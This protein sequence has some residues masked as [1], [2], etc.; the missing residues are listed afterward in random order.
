MK[1]KFLLFTAIITSLLFISCRSIRVI[2]VE[3][4][5]P[6]AIT[7]PPE[8]KTVMIVNNSAQQSDNIGHRYESNV[9]RDSVLSISTDST[10]YYFCR[11]LGKSML[12]SKIFDD[13]RLCEDTLRTDSLFYNVKPFSANK[14]RELCDDYEVDGIISLDKLFFSTLYQE[15]PSIHFNTY[16][17]SLKMQISGEVRALWPGQKEAFVV[18]FLDTLSWI[19]ESD[20]YHVIIDAIQNL[21]FTNILL[22][23]SEYTG[24]NM[25]VNF[26]PFWVREKRWYYTAITSEWKRG[27]AYAV[28]EKW[29]QA[30]EIWEPLFGRTNKWKQ[31]AR[32][33]S[34]LAVCYEMTGDFKKAAEYAEISHSIFKESDIE[35]S[36]YTAIQR[37]YIEILKKRIDSDKI[38]T[39]QLN[40]GE[41]F[42]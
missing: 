20:L 13:I 19:D 14:V 42:E 39:Q 35:G 16:N 28:V 1:R 11:A 7:F 30:A 24:Q 9:K 5:N 38:L 17:T 6:S 8:I 2:D 26:V 31:K 33:A 18:P 10:A 41:A 25:H 4:Y 3:T 29:G 23:L 34:N 32:L 12:E 15:F 37:S 27:T 40:K 22:Y 21:K 36:S